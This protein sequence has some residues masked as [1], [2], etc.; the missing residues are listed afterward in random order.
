[1]PVTARLAWNTVREALA[2]RL[3]VAVGIFSLAL[4]AAALGLGAL[5]V[6]DPARVTRDVGVAA[7]DLGGAA[8]AIVLAVALVARELHGGSADP[9]L[10]RGISRP[11]LIL[12]RWLG[13]EITLGASLAVL[14]LVVVLLLAAQGVRPDADLA[15]RIWLAV[16]GASVIAAL[17]TLLAALVRPLPAAAY[18]A[19]LFAIGRSVPELRL[20][21]RQRGSGAAA[22]ALDLL[23][24][25]LPNLQLF[26]GPATPASSVVWSTVYGVAYAAAAVALAAFVVRRRDF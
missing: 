24:R 13:V 12:A 6:D 25:L 1:M 15:R 10:T 22:S 5:V 19:A 7:L 9:V 16:I 3:V 8:L 26:A 18:S 21:A 20:L 4:A 2:A 11:Q 17:A 14:A 23:A